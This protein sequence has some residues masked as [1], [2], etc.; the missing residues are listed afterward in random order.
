MRVSSIDL[1]GLPR[2]R[3]ATCASPIAPR[4]PRRRV[5]P[6]CDVRPLAAGPRLVRPACHRAHF[7]RP[8]DF[9][10]RALVVVLPRGLDFIW[11]AAEFAGANL[12]LVRGLTIDSTGMTSA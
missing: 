5:A 11:R 6:E 4:S 8:A 2:L 10:E 1:A 12:R 7:E 9:L 3:R